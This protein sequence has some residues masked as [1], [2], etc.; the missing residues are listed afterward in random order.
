MAVDEI[1][2]HLKAI[3]N[4]EQIDADQDAIWQIRIRSRLFKGCIITDRSWI[5]YGQGAVHHHDVKDMLGLIDRTIIYDLI[6]AIHQNQQARVI[7]C[8]CNLGSKL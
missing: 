2:E 1:T 6:L 7:S 3:L 8:F 4:K 5:A